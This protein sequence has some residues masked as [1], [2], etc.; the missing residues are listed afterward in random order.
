[1]SRSLVNFKYLGIGLAVWGVV[2][3]ALHA[4]SGMPLWIAFA[5][6]VSAMLLNGL[7]ATLE[8]D[9]PG[10]FN[11]PDGTETPPYVAKVRW[12]ARVI[13]IVA[14]LL[15]AVASALFFYG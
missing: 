13:A 15:S 6:V 5:I 11:N 1:M 4:F 9:L 8:D 12:T 2:A 7:A 10:G 14:L 3:F